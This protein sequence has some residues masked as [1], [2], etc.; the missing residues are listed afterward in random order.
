MR[1]VEYDIRARGA[2]S[3]SDLDVEFPADPLGREEYRV[4]PLDNPRAD[5]GFGQ[6]WLGP[7]Y[8]D[9]VL[10]SATHI[11]YA[12]SKEYA[13]V[14]A[15]SVAFIYRR[16]TERQT[17]GVVAG[18]ISLGAHAIDSEGGVNVIQWF[19]RQVDEGPGYEKRLVVGESELTAYI[20]SREGYTE[21]AVIFPDAV[22]RFDAAGV[23]AEDAEQMIVNLQRV[24]SR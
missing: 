18:D 8:R 24:D 20:V 3:E 22:V 14:A 23:S 9:V 21:G 16:A 10:V 2:L 12:P 7:Q 4:L 6:Y 17:E 13:P 11:N 1:L 15:N 19:Q 5:V